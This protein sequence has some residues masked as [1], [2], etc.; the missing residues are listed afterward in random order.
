MSDIESLEM[1]YGAMQA[2]C[3]G[4]SMGRNVFERENPGKFLKA[5]RAIIHDGT[6]LEEGKKML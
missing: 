2:G 6:S 5:V 4:I 1:I 3:A